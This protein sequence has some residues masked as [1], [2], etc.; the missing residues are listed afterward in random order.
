MIFDNITFIL[1]IDLNFT[2][3]CRELKENG[4][5]FSADDYFMNGDVYCYEQR[6]L[7]DAHDHCRRKG[8]GQ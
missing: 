7:T 8:K 5:I 1:S 6:K 2:L 4:E 3:F